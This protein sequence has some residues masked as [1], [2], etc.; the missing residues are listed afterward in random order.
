MC[1]DS[2]DAPDAGADQAGQLTGPGLANPARWPN[3]R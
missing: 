1:Q 3:G 2:D